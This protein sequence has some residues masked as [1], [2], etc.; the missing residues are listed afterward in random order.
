MQRHVLSGGRY[1]VLRALAI[2]Y[3]VGAAL[4]AIST[5]ITFCYILFS[6][7]FA[8]M[9]RLIMCVAALGAGFF[10]IV[11]ALAIAEVLK[12]AIDIEHNTRMSGGTRTLV[13]VGRHDD[14]SRNGKMTATLADALARWMKK[15]P[16]R[17]CC[18]DISHASLALS[19]SRASLLAGCNRRLHRPYG[20]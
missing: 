16:R 19:V 5:A 12:L 18:A 15:R 9:D 11:T 3:V 17:R 14:G 20:A 13:S 8:L 2:I 6:V 7:R 10:L 1:P 4:A